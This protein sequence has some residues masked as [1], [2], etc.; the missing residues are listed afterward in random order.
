M[1]PTPAG[2]P[3]GGPSRDA[4]WLTSRELAAW[5]ELR[6]LLELLPSAL[7][8][9]TLRQT[10]VSFFEYQILATLSESDG[11]ARRLSELAEATSSSLSRL[12]H[13]VTRLE[14]KGY[15]LRRRCGGV[16]RSSVAVLTQR[17]LRKLA[18]AAPAHVACVRALVFDAL[19]DEQLGALKV[20]ASRIVERLDDDG[21]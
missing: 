21:G 11:R 10:G 8:S 15:V 19:S 7:D 16:G 1:A 4:H 18:S 13:A 5:L 3:P 20:I 17:G 14:S 6:R 2:A 12:S 9:R